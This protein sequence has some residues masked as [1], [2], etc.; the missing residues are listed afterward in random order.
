MR[1]HVE[2]PLTS[3][4]GCESNNTKCNTP[5]PHSHPRPCNS[6]KSHDTGDGKWLIWPNLTFSL[7]LTLVARGS[8]ISGCV[9]SYFEGT[10]NVHCYT[11]CTLTTLHCSRVS[12]L[13]PMKRYIKYLQKCEGCTDFC[14]ILYMHQLQKC[15]IGHVLL[16]IHMH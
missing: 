16:C 12:F 9:L 11:S 5:A 8:E 6:N 3:M 2:L 14:E 13:C 10:V 7:V 15:H 4:R 1:C